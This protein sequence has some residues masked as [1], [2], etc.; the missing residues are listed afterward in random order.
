MPKTLSTTEFIARANIKHNNFYDYSQVKYVNMHTKV[1]IVDP[2]YGEFYQVPLGHLDGQN[3]PSR[4]RLNSASKR[5]LSTETFINRAVEKYGDLYD[6]SFVTYTGIDTLVCIIDPLYGEFYQTPYNHL[7]SHGC[8]ERSKHKKFTV[9]IDHIIPLSIIHPG[10]R[11][12]DNWFKE[13]PL[14]KFLDS[15]INKQQ[16]SMEANLSK[17]DRVIIHGREIR[18]NSIRNNYD[19]ISYLIHTYLSVDPSRII[20]DDRAYVIQYLGL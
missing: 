8:P 20:S 4:G 5:R 17:S 15:N 1:C 19:A 14:Y 11:A 16:I 6:Y 18:C 9:H 7:H 12:F 13:R 2:D 3:H 10:N